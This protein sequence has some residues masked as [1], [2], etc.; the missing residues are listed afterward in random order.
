MEKVFGYFGTIESARV[1]SHKNCGFINFLR[2]E[3]A[4]EARKHMNGKEISGAIVKIGFAKVPAGGL[5]PQPIYTPT[6]MITDWSDM[7][8]KNNLSPPGRSSIQAARSAVPRENSK[9]VSE[10]DSY[11]FN[12][13]P[14]NPLDGLLENSILR[15]FRK[16]IE[17]PSISPEQI[18]EIFN[19][20]IHDAS[21]VSAGKNISVIA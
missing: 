9:S 21:S 6:D 10:E 4:V 14:I 3:D 12:I 5:A 15:E 8:P 2:V 1:L 7:S 11:Y 20:I 13:S 18:S 16:R 19:T 17:N